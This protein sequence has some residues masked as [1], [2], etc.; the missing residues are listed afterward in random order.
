MVNERRKKNE[1][2][3]IRTISSYQCFVILFF[4]VSLTYVIFTIQLHRSIVSS[5]SLTNFH[6]ISNL[7]RKILTQYS[8]SSSSRL[9]LDNDTNNQQIKQQSQQQQQQDKEDKDEGTILRELQYESFPVKLGPMEKI[10][11]P[12]SEVSKDMNSLKDEDY[13]EVPQFW[14]PLL[15]H[16][17]KINL[18]EKNTPSVFNGLKTYLGNFGQRLMTLKEARTIGSFTKQTSDNDQGQWLETIFVAIASYRDFQCSQTVESIFAR[19][20]YPERVRVS[21]VDQLATNEEFS[22]KPQ[23]QDKSNKNYTPITCQYIN[24]LD[25]FSLDAE[26]YGIG[27]VFARHI[28]HRMYRGEYFTMQ[29]DAHVDFIQNWDQLVIQQW[30]SAKNEMAVLTAYMSDITNSIDPISHK[31]KHEGRPIMCRSGYEGFGPRKHFRHGQQPEGVAMIKDQPMLEPFWAAGFSFARGHF[32]INVPYDQHL[33]MIFQGEEMNIGVRAFTYGYDFYAMQSQVCFHYYASSPMGAKRKKV[34]LFF[35]KHNRHGPEVETRAMHRLNTII[36]ARPT[37]QYDKTGV[38]FKEVQ[39]YGLGTVRS[40]DKFYQTFGIDTTKETV[41]DNLCRFVGK[42]MHYIFIQHLRDDT[43]GIDYSN[44][45]YKFVD[46]K[47]NTPNWAP[48]LPK[49]DIVKEITKI[50]QSKGSGVEAALK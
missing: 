31:S 48:L 22:C 35:D 2:K 23:C 16:Y 11:H 43:M 40:T 49:G 46:P 28:G 38:Y 14:D 32:I 27:P 34:P 41:Q 10:I 21:V 47:T 12:A 29:I 44:I 1:S 13:M 30:K 18:I 17:N 25:V 9:Q 19:A 20:K 8:S 42:P 24:Q 7:R 50:I 45:D 15:H 26:L 6:G 3:N 33:P 39:P 36:R 37:F 4:G 5:S